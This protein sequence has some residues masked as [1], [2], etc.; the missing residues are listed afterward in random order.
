M[1]IKG[2]LDYD[3]VNYKEPCLTVLFPHCS[4]K[5]DKDNGCQICQNW[6]LRLEDNYDLT[7]EEIVSY[8]DN[9][10]TKAFCFQGLEPLDSWEDLI[11]LVAFIRER[12]NNTIVIYTGYNKE[13]KQQEAALLKEYGNII[14]KW[15]RYLL[16]SESRFDD[17][18]G[19]ELASSNQ[20]AEVL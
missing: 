2:I 11:S 17:V 1:L 3:G 9:P 18:L 7:Y 16:N 4:F 20:Y 12:Y 13:E 5:C 19:V 14:I 10:L 15:G 6:A 8:F